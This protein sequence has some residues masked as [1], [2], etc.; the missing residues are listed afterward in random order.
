MLIY[1]P[2]VLAKSPTHNIPFGYL[3]FFYELCL[4]KFHLHNVLFNKTEFMEASLN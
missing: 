2:V 1:V 3:Q 4:N